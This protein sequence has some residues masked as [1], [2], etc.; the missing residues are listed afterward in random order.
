MRLT[1]A[2]ALL[3]SISGCALAAKGPGPKSSVDEVVEALFRVRQLS[4][5]AI[6]PDGGRV[7]WVQSHEDPAT[8]AST[9]SIYIQ[10]LGRG[11]V[12]TRVTAG[13]GTAESQEREIAWSPDGKRLAFISDAQEKGQL[14]LYVFDVATRRASKITNLT[15]ALQG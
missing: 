12:P 1:L 6:S 5:V 4:H 13:N 15:G 14:Q 8:G 10:E 9:L 7:G 11:G 3:L 2:S